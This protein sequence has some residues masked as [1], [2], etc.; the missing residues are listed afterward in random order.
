MRIER[1]TTSISWIPSDSIPGLLR[2]PFARGIMHYAHPQPGL[3]AHGVRPSHA[4]GR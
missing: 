4:L 1:A 3:G 2:L